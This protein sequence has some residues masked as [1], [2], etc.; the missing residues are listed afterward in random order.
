MCVCA[1][2]QLLFLYCTCSCLISQAL[3]DSRPYMDPHPDTGSL[4]QPALCHAHTHTRTHYVI[5]CIYSQ[6]SIH[7]KLLSDIQTMKG[8]SKYIIEISLFLLPQLYYFQMA[9]SS[10]NHI[11]KQHLL[12]SYSHLLTNLIYLFASQLALFGEFVRWI[13]FV[14]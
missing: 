1:L 9:Y 2:L 10:F 13:E 8:K 11:S 4:T 3:M 12:T 6:A 7:P 14:C 5:I